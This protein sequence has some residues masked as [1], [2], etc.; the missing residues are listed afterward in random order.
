MYDF[1][2]LRTLLADAGFSEIN[3]AAFRQGRV[4][5]LEIL[6]DQPA[7]SLF[8]EARKPVPLAETR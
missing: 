2:A 4:P 6:D 5:D 3:R 8:V 7:V 1:D